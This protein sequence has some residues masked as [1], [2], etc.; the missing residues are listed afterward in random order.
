MKEDYDEIKISMKELCESFKAL[1]KLK[2]ENKT[3]DIEY[4][5]GG[6]LKFLA[7]VLGINS[8]RSNHPCPWCEKKKDEFVTNIHQHDSLRNF[9][10]KLF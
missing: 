5:L 9:N 4:Y 2:S 7:L 6:D 8:A 10:S 3:Y 1:K